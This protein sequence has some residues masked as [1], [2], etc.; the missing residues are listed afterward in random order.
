MNREERVP[1]LFENVIFKTKLCHTHQMH[2][3]ATGVFHFRK[4]LRQIKKYNQGLKT[5]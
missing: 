3:F 5:R 1:W 4:L 2:V